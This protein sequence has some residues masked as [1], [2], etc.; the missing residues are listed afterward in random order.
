MLYCKP[1]GVNGL[2]LRLFPDVETP[3]PSLGN[4]RFFLRKL[5]FLP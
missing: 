3:V 2:M 5:L 4:Y 1:V